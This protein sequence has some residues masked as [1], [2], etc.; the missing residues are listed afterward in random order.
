MFISIH[1]FVAYSISHMNRHCRWADAD[2]GG[3]GSGLNDKFRPATWINCVACLHR[4]R[5]RWIRAGSVDGGLCIKIWQSFCRMNDSEFGQN[6]VLSILHLQE[7]EIF[8][9]GHN[10]VDA[11][12]IQV[13]IYFCNGFFPVRRPI[14]ATTTLRLQHSANYSANGWKLLVFFIQITCT[15]LWD[16]TFAMPSNRILVDIESAYSS[17]ERT[18]LHFGNWKS[19]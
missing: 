8:S 17:N 5:L 16:C 4:A 1:S 7:R 3:G 11:P 6:L 12:S 18:N 10:S 9:A 14:W 19:K 15:F 13:K 2:D